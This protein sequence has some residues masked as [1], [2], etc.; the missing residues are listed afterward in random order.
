MAQ[1]NDISNLSSTIAEQ[2]E[3]PRGKRIDYI[4]HS[5]GRGRNCKVNV[6]RLQNC[7]CFMNRK[8]GLIKGRNSIVHIESTSRLLSNVPSQTLPANNKYYDKVIIYCLTTWQFQKRY[9]LFFSF[10]CICTG[11]WMFPSPSSCNPCLSLRSGGNRLLLLR[12][13]YHIL[14]LLSI[15]IIEEVMVLS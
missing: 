9:F 4:L 5:A 2:E 6:T 1:G 10:T 3:Y 14:F 7:K 13:V 12:F 11:Y 15:L 8:L